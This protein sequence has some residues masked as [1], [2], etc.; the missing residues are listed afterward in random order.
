M[1][2]MPN[3]TETIPNTSAVAVEENKGQFQ[4]HALSKFDF[5]LYH[6]EDDVALPVIRVK[7][8]ALPNKGERWKVFSDN[9]VLH[10]IEGQKLTKKQCEFL[11]SVEGISWLLSRAKAGI[12]S[13]NAFKG[14]LK[15]KLVIQNKLVKNAEKKKSK[16]A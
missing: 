8:I 2:T 14:E 11:R 15:N 13:F 7:H 9:K 1:P 5:D 16:R 3:T 6:E 12:K 4:N 10:V